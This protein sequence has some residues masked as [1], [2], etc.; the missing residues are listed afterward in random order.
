MFQ[1]LKRLIFGIPETNTKASQ[2]QPAKP[3]QTVGMFLPA[4]RV[5][6]NGVEGVAVDGSCWEEWRTDPSGEQW[7]R[8]VSKVDAQPSEI[9]AIDSYETNDN[10]TDDQ[11][12]EFDELDEEYRLA[13]LMFAK[14]KKRAR[15][16]DEDNPFDIQEYQPDD[17]K[18][19]ESDD[20]E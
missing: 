1:N 11:L 3:V 14:H 12:D 16:R 5:P 6:E 9:H 18:E 4:S 17:P 8:R 10:P 13:K 15:E 19:Y 2:S 20:D 7:F